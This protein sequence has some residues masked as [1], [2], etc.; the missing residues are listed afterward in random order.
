MPSSYSAR[1]RLELQAA[2]ENLTT[3]GAPKLNNVISRIDFSIAGW[4]TIAL[5]SDYTLTASNSD[6]EARSAMLKFTGSGSYAVTIPSVSKAYHIWNAS[7]GITTITT[8]AGD[9]VSIDPGAIL[10]V[11]CDGSNVKEPG[12][13]GL[14]LKTYIDQAILATT[15]SLPATVGNDGKALVCV[16][17]AWTPTTLTLSYISD[18]VAPVFAT[19]NDVRAGSSSTVHVS[20]S[21]LA[22]SAAFITLTDA[23]TVAW[24]MASGYNAKVTLGGNRALGAPTNAYEGLSGSLQVIQDGTGSRTLSFDSSWDFG[25]N[26]AP[27]L[28]TAA[29]SIDLITWI[30]I[31]TS[32][33]KLRASFQA[34]A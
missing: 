19:A 9:T 13:S 5:T 21:A 20:P 6:D 28:S 33:L 12:Y 25:V 22:G 2:G 4:T 3:W 23:S 24:N 11:I 14:G 16:S 30:C 17:G 15:G 1:L 32:P 18:Y 8:G 34:S 27:T 31:S 10:W 29:A 26:G 7:T